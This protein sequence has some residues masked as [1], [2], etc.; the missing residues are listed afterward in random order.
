M[1]VNIGVRLLI[2][3]DWSDVAHEAVESDLFPLATKRVL[4]RFFL[5]E[6]D[7]M[8]VR[9]PSV[10][11]AVRDLVTPH[12]ARD[13]RQQR[14][15][16][17]AVATL[18]QPCQ[19]LLKMGE[20]FR[21]VCTVAHGERDQ[22]RLQL[23]MLGPDALESLQ[24]T[25][26]HPRATTDGAEAAHQMG[27]AEVRAAQLRLR[28]RREVAEQQPVPAGLNSRDPDALRLRS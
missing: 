16:P 20:P 17:F 7:R 3:C 9:M 25:R 27:A 21:E 2:R 1:R 24:V 5:G 23:W 11:V 6:I 19:A 12:R 8:H 13:L 22:I 26:H 15:R 18:V 28:Q 14:S 4:V 10:L